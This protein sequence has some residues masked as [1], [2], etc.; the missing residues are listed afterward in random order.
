MKRTLLKR[1]LLACHVPLSLV[2]GGG[3]KPANLGLKKD[4]LVPLSLVG[5]GG[6]KQKLGGL[7]L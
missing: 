1:L 2:G 3:L 6:L 4:K 5:G 7:K